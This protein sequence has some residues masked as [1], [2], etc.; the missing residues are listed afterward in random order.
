MKKYLGMFSSLVVLCGI[1]LIAVSC[2]GNRC[3]GRGQ[4]CCNS[5]DNVMYD[6]QP[7]G[8]QNGPRY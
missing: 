8:Y 6:N 5:C 2:S 4:D 3:C 7:G 1:A